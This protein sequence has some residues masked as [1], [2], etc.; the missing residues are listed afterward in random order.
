MKD[1]NEKIENIKKLLYEVK[2]N[3]IFVSKDMGSFIKEYI[4][5][6]SVYPLSYNNKRIHINTMVN[7]EFILDDD[8][9]KDFKL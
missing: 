3:E 2:S 5:D 7:G 8:E 9:F 6:K 1:L 4:V